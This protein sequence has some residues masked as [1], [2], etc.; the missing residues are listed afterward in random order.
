[1]QKL[2]IIA[3]CIWGSILSILLLQGCGH[4]PASTLWAPS[5][6]DSIVQDGPNV[7]P[8]ALA[9]TIHLF[10]N[11]TRNK[12]GQKEL[13]WSENIA[14]VA[15]SHSVDMS[16]NAFFGHIN[17]KG[18]SATERAQRLG[19]TS[20]Q[21]DNQYVVTGLGENLFATHRYWQYVIT[22]DTTHTSYDVDW[23]DSD[24]IAR[25][26]VEAWLK[27]PAHRKNLL[28]PMYTRQGIGVSI[29]SNG[30]IFITQNFN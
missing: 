30:T 29:G 6:P 2:N 3:V 23:K 19:Y 25:E 24:S 9:K 7:E 11:E 28:S 4:K 16:E 15:K 18:E 14:R 5:I 8:D 22:R 26:A 10:T 21:H 12:H 20:L 13:L 17:P 1:M 27:S